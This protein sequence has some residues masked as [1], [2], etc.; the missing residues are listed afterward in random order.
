MNT[1]IK[2]SK[3][4]FR[5]ISDDDYK[6]QITEF[7]NI[8]F[9]SEKWHFSEVDTDIAIVG[10]PLNNKSIFMF[11]MYYEKLDVKDF[12]CIDDIKVLDYKP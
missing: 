7:C 2:F 5:F 10:F 4:I 11:G 1:S 8:V 12:F 9:T 6:R 3:P